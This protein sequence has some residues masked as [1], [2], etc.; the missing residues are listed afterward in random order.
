[1][2]VG[3]VSYNRTKPSAAVPV[4][5][6]AFSALKHTV[7]ARAADIMGRAMT[8]DRMPIPIID[9]TPNRAVLVSAFSM[10]PWPETL[11]LIGRQSHR[12]FR[13]M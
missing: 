5:I 3:I 7:P 13:P 9:P 2:I 12:Y 4:P 8:T 1:M 10:L 11:I 6:T